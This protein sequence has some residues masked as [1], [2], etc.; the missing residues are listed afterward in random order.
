MQMAQILDLV[1]LGLDGLGSDLV[2]QPCSYETISWVKAWQITLV[3]LDH[4]FSENWEG[5]VGSIMNYLSVSVLDRKSSQ[6][7]KYLTPT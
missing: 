6:H 7:K 5:L 1:A 3:N 4:E 2:A